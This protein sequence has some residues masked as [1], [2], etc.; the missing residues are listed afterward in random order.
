MS[1]SY[2]LKRMR[3]RRQQAYCRIIRV[4]EKAQRSGRRYANS[5]E[6]RQIDE[7]RSEIKELDERIEQ[8]IERGPQGAAPTITPRHS[9]H[10]RYHEA[11]H[12]LVGYF[13]GWTLEGVY[14]A[15]DDT[16]GC[17]FVDEHQDPVVCLGG[18]A[19]LRSA[20]YSQ[21]ES[22]NG[23]ENDRWRAQRYAEAECGGSVR[24]LR[25]L[26]QT[27][28]T[29]AS[30]LCSEQHGALVAL[31]DALAR[32]PAL[33]RPQV[34]RIIRAKANRHTRSWRWLEDTRRSRAARRR[35]TVAA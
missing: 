15:D 6:N 1:D 16:G 28:L 8:E 20:G 31:A 25:A 35:Q 18:I 22:W 5:T 10:L 4:L 29:A 14:V 32:K 23:A 12:A 19:A 26:L 33:S 24:D 9:R 3:D 13:S 34:E 11:G 27:Y 2:Q 17:R 30:T 21:R 7:L